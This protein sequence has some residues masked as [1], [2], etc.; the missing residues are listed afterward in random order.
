[1]CSIVLVLLP[2]DRFLQSWIGHEF[3][4]QWL[5]IHISDDLHSNDPIPVRLFRC[6]QCRV[7]VE[8]VIMQLRTKVLVPLQSLY[9]E[10]V[11]EDPDKAVEKV[12]I[13]LLRSCRVP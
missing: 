9:V 11:L 10:V 13:G 6:E 2:K 1:M 5:C 7:Q 12:G 4:H 8:K 3:P